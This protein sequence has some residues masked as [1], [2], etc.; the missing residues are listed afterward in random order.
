SSSKPERILEISPEG[1]PK[2]EIGT[3]A[4]NFAAALRYKATSSARVIVT[5]RRAGP[6]LIKI[7]RRECTAREKRKEER[8]QWDCDGV[9][10][11]GKSCEAIGGGNGDWVRCLAEILRE[12]ER[13]HESCRGTNRTGFHAAE[14]GQEG[15]EAFGL[16]REEERRAGVLSAG[17]EPR[18]HERTRLL[19]ER[20]EAVRIAGRRGAGGER[21]Q[22]LVAQSLRGQDGDQILAAGGFASAGSDGGEIRRLSGGQGDH[23]AGH[24]DREQ[25][26]E[27]RLDEELRHSGGTGR[28]GSRCGALASKGRKRLTRYLVGGFTPVWQRSIGSNLRPRLAE[29]SEITYAGSHGAMRA[30]FSF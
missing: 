23:G 7:Y 24:R 1:R 22:R 25:G 29:R 14:S 21:G 18:V 2:A 6:A 17:L 13:S 9:E 28:E 27:N 4:P 16:C 26:G 5:A 3:G 20:H 30:R 15:S 12:R 19:C 11:I 8:T 10:W